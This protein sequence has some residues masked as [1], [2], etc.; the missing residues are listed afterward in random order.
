MKKLHE[1]S[2]GKGE[3]YSAAKGGTRYGR[4]GKKGGTE[5]PPFS[6]KGRA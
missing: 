6:S 3:G 4:Q 5:A 2:Y 1:D